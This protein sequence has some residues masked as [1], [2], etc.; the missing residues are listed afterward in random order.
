MKGLTLNRIRNT[1]FKEIYEKLIVGN[2]Q[3]N[4]EYK[5]LLSLAIIFI[6][7]VNS[8]VSRL[9]YRILVFYCNLTKDYRPLYDIALNEGLIPIVKLIESLEKYQNKFEETFFGSLYS[10]YGENY[11]QGP[12]YLSDQQQELFTFFNEKLED[13]VSVVA[14][15]SY[16]KSELII[17]TLKQRNE[18]NVCIIVPTKALLAQTKRR[19]I[20]G[21]IENIKKIIT[22]PEMFVEGEE[23]ITA[24]LT[25]E[26]LLRLLRK[27]PELSFNLVFIDEAH[28]LL[29]D[30]DRN[31]L[32]AATI[33]ILEKRNQNVIFKFLT[34]FLIDSSNLTVKY[35]NY[36]LEAFRITEYIK[37]EKFYIY[38]FRDSKKFQIYDHFLNQFFKLDVGDFKD[39]VDFIL[40]NQSPKNLIYLNKPSDIEKLSTRFVARTN[41]IIS[42]K[43]QQA[44]AELS[45][46]M[47]P[48]YFMIKCLRKGFIYHHGS[49]PD[50]VRLYIEHLFST[51]MELKFVITSSTLLEG[52]N[53]PVEKM[54]LLDNKKGRRILSPSQFKNLIGRV[55]RFSEV[56]SPTDGGLEKLEPKIYLVGSNYF[57][58]NANIE[59]FI[60]DSMKVDKE[61]KDEPVNVLLKNVS[62]SEANAAKKDEADEFIENFEPGVISNYKKKL[63]QTELGKLCFMNNISEIDVI[64][65]EHAMQQI[66]NGYEMQSIDSAEGVFEAFAEIF[67]PFIKNNDDYKNLSRLN[68]KESQR[69]YQMFLNWRIK[70]ASYREMINS[71]L[72]YWN[73]VEHSN[74]STDI[75]VGRWG[76]KKRDGHRELWTDIKLKSRA[77]R[78]NLAI[79]RIKDEQ[80]F[81]DNTFIKYI[82][83]MNDTGI[84]VNEFYE[85]IKYGTTDKY[86]I[87]LIK[88][89]LSSGLSNLII[90]D[91]RTFVEIDTALNTIVIKPELVERMI[92]Q[93]E[94]GILIHEV[95]Y[96]TKSTLL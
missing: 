79:V 73:E 54:F 65:N 2:I 93:N 59:N 19:L 1:N 71:F 68:F 51:E 46:Y 63:A 4:I 9:G 7:D 96:N 67:L 18:G 50:N 58:K 60:R 13:T 62:I 82:E 76:D 88:N 45:E 35:S 10:A 40:K 90:N 81:L 23:N 66:I 64:T 42:E 20:K 85:K 3:D 69:F 37:T 95:R 84:M 41:E 47:H 87:S 43:I 15:T 75:Y 14:P 91:Y 48:D 29:E 33:S 16:G 92:E 52:V 26:R 17:S 80:D 21:E 34:P 31:I 74:E 32:L 11:K 22:H 56:F 38:D 24:V 39:D 89:G 8:D 55:N 49:V 86:K 53:L 94:N 12:I 72:K 78:I 25:Q 36:S 57:S 77:Q 83:V 5:K 44:C 6:N 70:N 30:N 28:N 27:N 61:V